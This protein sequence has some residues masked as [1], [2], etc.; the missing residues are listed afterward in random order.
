MSHT[1]LYYALH[2]AVQLVFL[3][4]CMQ[5]AGR[6]LQI[7]FGPVV[8]AILKAALVLI[9]VLPFPYLLAPISHTYA[10]WGVYGVVYYTFLTIAFGLDKFELFM[11][12]P[13]CFFGSWF[14]ILGVNLT[15]YNV[16]ARAS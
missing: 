8:P 10:V 6:M 13:I 1:V 5:V 9:L 16:F 11:F 12:F 15:L 3:V 14:V 7:N 2:F 4:L